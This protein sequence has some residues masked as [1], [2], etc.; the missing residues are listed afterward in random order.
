MNKDKGIT[1]T[2]PKDVYDG[3]VNELESLR[4]I[5]ASKSMTVFTMLGYLDGNRITIFN[6]DEYAE[7][8]NS[9]MAAAQELRDSIIK[10]IPKPAVH[11]K[12]VAEEAMNSVIAP[13]LKESKNYN[14]FWNFIFRRYWYGRE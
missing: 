3:M 1:V 7:R 8:F 4:S 6:P 14:R 10:M 2:L 13:A 5:I 12:Y 9:E 11:D